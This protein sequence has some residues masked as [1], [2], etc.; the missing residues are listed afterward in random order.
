MIIVA[1]TNY[2]EHNYTKPP[3]SIEAEQAVLGCLMLNP[4]LWENV[5]Q[6]L[7][8]TDFY[9]KEHILIFNTM[10]DL[11]LEQKPIDIITI[12]EQLEIKNILKSVGG[13]AYLGELTACVSNINNITIYIEII[14]RKSKLRQLITIGTDIINYCYTPG[15]KTLTELLYKTEYKLQKIIEIKKKNTTTNPVS[16]A[17]IFKRTIRTIDKL[18]ETKNS[19]TGLPT[20][21]LKLDLLTSGLQPANLIV[22]AGRPSMGKTTFALNIAE[23]I[24]LNSKKSIIMFSME[25]QSEQLA[26]KLLASLSKINIQ[27]IS[28]GKLNKTDWKKLSANIA[29]MATKKLFIDDTG[30]LNPIEIRNRIKKTIKKNGKTSLVIIDYLQLMKI[31]GT[32]ETRTTEISEITRSLKMIAKEFNIPVLALSQLNRNLEQRQDKR[33]MMS[34]LR[35]SGAI[36][37]DADLILFIYRDE[38]YN[39]KTTNRKDAE[40]IIGKQRNGPTGTLKLLFNGEYSRFENTIN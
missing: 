15:E 18:A 38:V 4:N 33:P 9:R 32:R 39:K 6:N 8:N 22:I 29:F 14:K 5:T 3:H 2:N 13:L 16:L 24:L 21:F 23:H 28:T 25:M 37:Q 1:K 7:H 19:I 31:P 35:E 34:D 11:I 26:I 10:F 40:I 17:K 36:E 20:G 27:N 12:S 30:S